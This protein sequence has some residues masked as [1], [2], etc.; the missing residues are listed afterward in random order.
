MSD[1]M[2]RM[3]L[4]GLWETIVMTFVSGFFGFVIGLPACVALFLKRDGQILGMDRLPQSRSAADDRHEAEPADQPRQRR[5][6][7]IATLGVDQRRAQYRQGD[8]VRLAD[9]GNA[10]FGVKQPS[11]GFP[12]ARD[13]RF[14][15]GQDAGRTEDDH[16][17]Q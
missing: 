12:L 15:F 13:F 8:V 9:R 6:L 1:S 17:F 2:L 5:D 7:G 14:Q 10:S 11:H 4:N 3:L 16:A